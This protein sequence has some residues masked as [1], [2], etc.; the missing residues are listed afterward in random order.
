MKKLILFLPFILSAFMFPDF[1]PCLLKYSYIKNS[2]PVSK[3]YSLKFGAEKCDIYDPFTKMCFIKHQNKRVLKFFVYPKLGWWA[4]SIKNDEIY[5]GNYAK[6][7]I[8][9][10][11]ALLSVKSAKNSVIADMF[12]RAIGVGRG[13][14]FIK[15]DMVTHFLKYRYWGDIGIDVNK[16]MEIISFDPFYVK[17]VKL[18]DKIL[19]INGKKADVR[20]FEEAVIKGKVSNC[21]KLTLQDKTISVS[22]RKRKYLYTPLEIF[23][24]YVNKNLEVKLSKALKK[25]YF[26]K[27]GAKIVKVNGIK[28]SSFKELKRA[29]S[30]YNNVTI[31]LLQN[32]LETK[33]PLR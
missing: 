4:G 14:G 3:N 23:G 25:R 15:A 13:D 28:I 12:C 33:I 30:T 6:K 19:K 5:V 17:G 31:T 32:G 8:F 18:G 26:L 24:I 27:D 1:R 9:F 10:T 7:E 2:L 11:P 16:N 21:V 20:T 22:I 29:L